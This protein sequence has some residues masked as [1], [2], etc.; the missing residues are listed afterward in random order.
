MFSENTSEK[1]EGRKCD[2]LTYPIIYP[3]Q[4]YK[5]LIYASMRAALSS[6]IRSDT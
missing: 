3:L 6:F 1:V 5:L 2:L 4:V